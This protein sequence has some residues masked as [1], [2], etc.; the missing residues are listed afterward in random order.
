MPVCFHFAA[1]RNMTASSMR[2][3]IFRGVASREGGIVWGLAR[4]ATIGVGW[5]SCGGTMFLKILL[6]LFQ[7]FEDFQLDLISGD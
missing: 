6:H 1:G 2:P 4:A 5:W 3:T 7:E